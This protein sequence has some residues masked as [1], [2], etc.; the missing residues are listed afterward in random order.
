MVICAINVW[1]R[2]AIST[3]QV[4]LERDE[5]PP[6]TGKALSKASQGGLLFADGSRKVS[7]MLRAPQRLVKAITH[8]LTELI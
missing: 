6:H 5:A 3:H 7:P 8:N 1:N 4:L 2:M